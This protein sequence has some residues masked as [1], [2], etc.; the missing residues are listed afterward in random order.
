MGQN[1]IVESEIG[2]LVAVSIVVP[3]ATAREIKVDEK[4]P[5]IR[6]EQDAHSTTL[7]SHLSS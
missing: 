5:N 3:I 4:T 1:V 6:F 2:S 7:H